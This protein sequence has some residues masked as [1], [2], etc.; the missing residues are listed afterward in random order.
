M[1]VVDVKYNASYNRYIYI[2]DWFQFIKYASYKVVRNTSTYKDYTQHG[3]HWTEYWMNF[4]IKYDRCRFT[5][6]EN[7]WCL[8]TITPPCEQIKYL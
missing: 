4:T 2:F 1:P 8:R 7:N 5:S 3:T 6:I